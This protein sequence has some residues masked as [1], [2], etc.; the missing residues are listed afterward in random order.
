[1]IYGIRG[2]VHFI[3][4]DKGSFISKLVFE[5]NA[6]EGKVTHYE[7]SADPIDDKEK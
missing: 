1:M 7:V 6:T 4:N 5:D 2:D 3:S